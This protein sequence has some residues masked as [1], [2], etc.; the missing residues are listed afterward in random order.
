MAPLKAYLT[1][2][3][4]VPQTIVA[5][6]A[7]ASLAGLGYLIYAFAS[8]KILDA[9]VDAALPAICADVRHQRSAIL[10]A[11]EAYKAQFGPYPPDHVVR[12][13]PTVVDPITNT[14]LYE[15]AGVLYDPTNRFFQ[16]A[17]LEPAEER[18]VTNFFGV[19]RF[20]NCSDRSDRLKHFLSREDMTPVQLHDDP[21]VFALGYNILSAGIAPELIWEIRASTWR[22]VSSS[23]TNNPGKFDLWIELKHKDWT[24][25]V[26]NWK[27]VE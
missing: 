6:L 7:V 25:V 26:G 3:L 18:Y 1:R 15:L 2:R 19:Q 12:L 17:G 24:K 22:Y 27:A 21:D 13:Q 14:L 11:L 4:T 20:K 8:A 10:A 9:R 16:V 5:V 23:P